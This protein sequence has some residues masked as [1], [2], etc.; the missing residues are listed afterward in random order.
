MVDTSNSIGTKLFSR[1]GVILSK[2]YSWL[3]QD[4]STTTCTCG[5][6]PKEK[7]EKSPKKRVLDWTQEADEAF[8]SL[9]ERLSTTP[10]LAYP[11]FRRG[12]VLEVDASLKGLGACLQQADESGKLH[13]I[14]YASR[15]LR[16]AEKNYTD[17]SSFKLELLALKWAVTD[18]FKQYLLGSNC[19]VYTDNNPLTHLQSAKLGATEQR[20]VAQL[21]S[22]TLD[23]RY[24]P[25][26]Q[27]R[28]ADALSRCPDN[29]K[30]LAQEECI[31]VPIEVVE[32]GAQAVPM[33]EPQALP[34]V[35]PSYP[36]E[37][38]KTM[39]LEDE[40]L[41]VVWGCWRSGWSPGDEIEPCT[42]EIKGWLKEFPKFLEENVTKAPTPKV[43]TPRRHLLAFRPFELV[44][45]DFLKL[46]VGKGGYEDVL[47]ITDAFT[48]F[49]QAIPCRNQTTPLLPKRYVRSGFPYGSTKITSDRGRNFESN[50][51]KELCKLYGI[52]KTRTTPYYPQGNGQTERFNRTLC[53]MIRSLDP[54]KRDWPELLTHLVFVYNCTS[55]RVT[56][57]SH[58]N[59]IWP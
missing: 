44:A 18:K 32:V 9:K 3:C 22:F 37:Q 20:W 53:G 30:I 14:A 1:V 55:H 15:G 4:V 41:T 10:L 25:G 49:A 24:K 21:A 39:Q 13:P 6:K 56:G 26:R 12:F 47:V 57:L 17:L 5:H 50:L 33:A 16:G 59:A 34:C 36:H 28:C 54:K 46:D 8:N 43:R 2:V 58:S 27:N 11:D 38:L 51:I 35:L 31:V 52:T 40:A 19:I 29:D 7:G 42:P 48:K 45:I 23:I